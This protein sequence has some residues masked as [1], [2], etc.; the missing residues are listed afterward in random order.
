MP[1]IGRKS[2]N[3]ILSTLFGDVKTKKVILPNQEDLPVDPKVS[4]P[5]GF[6]SSEV[7]PDFDAVKIF[8]LL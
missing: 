5:K 3:V 8:S 4:T 2:A 1:G 7:E 6:D